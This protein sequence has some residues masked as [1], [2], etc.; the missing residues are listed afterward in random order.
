MLAVLLAGCG[1]ALTANSPGPAIAE[2][3]G[4]LTL[5]D[6]VSV[7]GAVRLATAWY[8]DLTDDA[9]T[10][11]RSIVTEEVAYTGSFP[12]NFTFRLHGA[13][14]REALAPAGEAQAP[15]GKG[16]VA[17]LFAYDD[18]DGDGKLTLDAQGRAL[19]R[20]L[21][22]SAGAGAFD[23]Y[24]SAVRYQLVWVQGGAT[25]GLEGVRPGYNLLRYEDPLSPPRVLPLDTPIPLVLDAAPRLA[26][27]ACPEA[28]VS[29]QPEVACGAR[30]WTTPEVNGAIT[31]QDDGSLDATVL[32][33]VNGVASRDAR[34]RINGVDVPVDQGETYSLV[35]PA[36]TASV[37]R[38][39]LNTVTVEHPGYEPLTLS[40][41]VPTRFDL[42]APL[43]GA[44]V[45]AGSALTISW[46]AATGATLYG[47]NLFVANAPNLG[48][49]ELT[50]D[51][52]VTLTV[53]D[54]SGPGDLSVVAYD[55]FVLSRAAVL[56]LSVRSQPLEVT[57]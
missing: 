28:Y 31:L 22:S 17:Q 47:A 27:I 56:G 9:P 12:Q 44:Q 1:P 41:V 52:T 39:G 42:R 21:G 2:L 55:R 51:T 34:V 45:R 29:P 38:V 37:L 20:I 13:P 33:G 57:R 49:S 26:L 11:P 40:A 46:S 50:R 3:N 43:A 8:P 23:F 16:A 5:A 53:P 54:G 18:L 15:E 14:P 25:F 4:V 36:G 30:V 35:E 7:R 24:T 32:V 6:G 19:D 10:P 48:S